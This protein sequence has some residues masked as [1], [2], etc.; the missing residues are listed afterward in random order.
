MM[1]SRLL[2]RLVLAAP[3]LVVACGG[4]DGSNATTGSDPAAVVEGYVAAYNA[5][6]IDRVMTFFAED[7]VVVGGEERV[8]G[9]ERIEGAVAIRA[10]TLD[11]FTVHAP[12]G[13]GVIVLAPLGVGVRIDLV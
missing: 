2:L 6:D 10:G 4:D 12:G 9:G 1:R 5:W 7:A 3:F 8:G 13:E 11:E